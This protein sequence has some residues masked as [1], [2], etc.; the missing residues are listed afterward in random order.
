MVQ[1]T[2][3]LH[4]TYP[5]ESGFTRT[6]TRAYPVP[7]ENFDTIYSILVEQVGAEYNASEGRFEFHS[8]GDMYLAIEKTIYYML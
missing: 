8:L 5:D 3:I 2:L 6:M 1:K 4:A 7:S